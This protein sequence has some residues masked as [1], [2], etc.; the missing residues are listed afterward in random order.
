MHNRMHPPAPS[1]EAVLSVV[2][3]EL[4]QRLHEVGSVSQSEEGTGPGSAQ[5]GGTGLLKNLNRTSRIWS[6]QN[7]INMVSVEHSAQ[8]G[9]N[10]TTGPP[11]SH[12]LK[13]I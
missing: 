7:R 12:M 11:V 10:R 9:F 13:V 8:T 2:V 1:A 4:Q 6:C 5:S 3:L